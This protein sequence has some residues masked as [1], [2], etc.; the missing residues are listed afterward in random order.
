MG[1]WP[2]FSLVM[3]AIMFAGCVIFAENSP[4][5]PSVELSLQ[6]STPPRIMV[7]DGSKV[8]LTSD[9][10]SANT[11]FT[12]LNL[13][14]V[15]ARDDESGV[16]RIKWE[17]MMHRDCVSEITG[18]IP[19]PVSI[20]EVIEEGNRDGTIRKEKS[21]Q[22]RPGVWQDCVRE[23]LRG[24][25]ITFTVSAVNGLGLEA[26][27][28]QI[29][30]VTQREEL[31]V[32]TFNLRANAESEAQY[33]RMLSRWAHKLFRHADIVMLQ[34]V[35]S[36][37][38]LTLLSQAGQL[39][40]IAAPPD[41]RRPDV[42][43]LSRLPIKAQ[44]HGYAC[45]RSCDSSSGYGCEKSCAFVAIKSTFLCQNVL[46]VS[47]HWPRLIDDPKDT[48]WQRGHDSPFDLVKSD[49]DKN[50]HT[51]IG[52]HF[53]PSKFVSEKAIP[54]AEGFDA[55]SETSNA[56]H[57]APQRWDRINYR[58]AGNGRHLIPV[59]YKTCWGNDVAPASHP[60]TWQLYRLED[61]KR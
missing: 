25:R 8:L 9:A 46:A 18:G 61:A 28:P 17:G 53:A 32:A 52:G 47:T 31:R 58:Q 43:I 6:D 60:F 30:I 12:D 35:P 23:T 4:R 29:E 36:L 5:A 3:S 27:T 55:F 10:A 59:T 33:E 34:D 48:Q 41:A 11:T 39:P 2:K 37:D 26:K 40:H 1:H 19:T 22:F 50:T 57:C 13:L 45:E 16:I 24:Y 14:Q 54:Y 42:A 38:V 49:Q 7:Q 21:Y 15:T 20:D 44:L 51:F 56:E